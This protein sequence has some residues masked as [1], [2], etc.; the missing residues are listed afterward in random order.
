MLLLGFRTC[1]GAEISQYFY[2]KFN[3]SNSLKGTGFSELLYYTVIN[4][5]ATGLLFGW[6][7]IVT[8]FMDQTYLYT[9]LHN[10]CV[11]G[12]LSDSSAYCIHVVI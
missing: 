11:T 9:L 1:R 10:M 2:F 8:V 12:Y 7:V 4:R 6:L 5:F 3:F